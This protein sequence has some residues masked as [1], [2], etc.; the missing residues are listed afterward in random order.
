MHIV[1]S[2]TSLP[3]TPK[4]GIPPKLTLFVCD[5]AKADIFLKIKNVCFFLFGHLAH[6]VGA[7]K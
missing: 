3:S 7:L 2:H 4:S 5:V 6:A 1:Q